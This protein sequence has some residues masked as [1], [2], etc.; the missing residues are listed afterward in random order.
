MIARIFWCEEKF[1][2]GGERL[3]ARSTEVVPFSDRVFLDSQ[4]MMFK[5]KGQL[6]GYEIFDFDTQDELQTMER[7]PRMWEE[8]QARKIDS[9][10]D[11]EAM[12][13]SLPKKSKP[14]FTARS[15]MS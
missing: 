1:A 10:Y 5:L 4:L 3:V 6:A 2:Q 12:A 8:F 13:S 11:R 9:W 15:F 14:G 7:D